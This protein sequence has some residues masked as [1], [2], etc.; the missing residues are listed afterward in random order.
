MSS[1][2]KYLQG[3]RRVYR[4]VQEGLSNAYRHAGGAGQKVEC[5]AK[6]DTLRIAVSDTG[7][8]FTPD[9][10]A[11][12]VSSQGGLGLAGLRDRIESLG[13]RFEI[14][15]APGR[16]TRLEMIVDPRGED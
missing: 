16:G 5:R 13:A 10:D 7:G 11:G 9:A 12:G 6:P 1:D 15:A 2:L 14:H 3:K 8:G 4:F